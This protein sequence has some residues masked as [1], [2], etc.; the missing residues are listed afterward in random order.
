MFDAVR[1]RSPLALRTTVVGALVAVTLWS[2][3]VAYLWA[4]E[5]VRARLSADA[6][7][8]VT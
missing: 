4:N 3:S 8:A 2:T 6:A 5:Y 1:A 7:P